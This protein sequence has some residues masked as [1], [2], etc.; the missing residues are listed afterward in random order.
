MAGY[1]ERWQARAKARLVRQARL[2][3]QARPFRQARLFRLFR[4]A[5]QFGR[6][7]YLVVL[8]CWGL[9]QENYLI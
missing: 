8:E 1:L 4:Q 3:R 6:P 2:F 9:A 7:G 5:R